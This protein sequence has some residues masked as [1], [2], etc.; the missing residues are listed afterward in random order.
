MSALS[1]PEALSVPQALSGSEI[2]IVPETVP[3]VVEAVPETVPEVAETEV[4]NTEPKKKAT[5]AKAKVD[6]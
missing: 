1:V 6:V 4:A 3:E 5:K 2:V